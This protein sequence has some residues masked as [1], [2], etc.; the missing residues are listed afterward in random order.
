MAQRKYTESD[1]TYFSN[2]IEKIQAKPNMYVGSTSA[3]GIFGIFREV[4]DNAVDEH[5]AGRNTKVDIIFDKNKQEVFVIDA[6]VGIPVKTHPKAKISTLTHIVTAL[7]SS[8]KINSEAYKNAAGTHGVGITA[9][10]ALSEE[11]EVWTYRKDSGGWHHTLF[12]NGK[13]ISK[14]KKTSKVPFKLK[15]GTVV[16]VIP[17][18][19]FFGDAKLDIKKVAEWCELTSFLNRGLKLSLQ[20]GDKKKEW[21][22]KNGITDY[23]EKKVADLKCTLEHKKYFTYTSEN[24][25]ISLAFTDAEGANID[26]FTNTVRNIEGGVHAD[27]MIKAM[28]AALKPFGPKLSYTD[29]D[30]FDGVVGLLNYNIN[31]AQFDSQTKEKLV[32]TRVA[33]PALDELTKAFTEFFMSNRT[34]GYAWVKRAAEIRKRT[35]E[36]LKSK[37]LVKNVKDAKLKISTKL[38]AVN[39]KAKPEDCELYLVEG[40]SA[41]GTA[42]LA[43]NHDTQAV[44]P[45]KGKPLNVMEAPIDRIQANVEIATILAAIGLD[46]SSEN[47]TAKM[48]YG[49]IIMLADADSDGKHITTLLLTVFWKFAPE[50]F[51]KGC[52]YSVKSPEYLTRWKDKVFF[53][54]SRKSVLAKARKAGAPKNAKLVVNHLKGW[55]EIGAKDLKVSAMLPGKRKLYK[56]NPPNTKDG[57]IRFES[58]MGKNVEYRKSL[59]GVA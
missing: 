25:E 49:K 38:A 45:L 24:I 21:V 55:G 10:N 8:G 53:G 23:L 43:R 32:D 13:E 6:G 30:L 48:P 33:K 3:I 31:D 37:K 4:F 27:A 59:M 29:K 42:K 20:V 12:K 34:F 47:P 9:T 2:D 1:V 17:S 40:D 35:S 56:V 50:L 54:S 19:K 44:F 15:S 39:G 14:V 28:K 7:Q 46:L 16:R 22:S 11:F 18:K 51:E 5:R 36:F 57:K 58:L 41:A 52:I 26:F